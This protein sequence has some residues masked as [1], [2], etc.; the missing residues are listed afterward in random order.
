MATVVVRGT[1]VTPFLVVAVVELECFFVVLDR[2]LKPVQMELGNLKEDCVY[3]NAPDTSDRKNQQGFKPDGTP[4]PADVAKKTKGAII[5]DI[6]IHGSGGVTDVVHIF[7]LKFPCPSEE[8]KEGQW[9]VGQK[10]KYVRILK[11]PATLI[12]P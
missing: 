12:S 5:P 2:I 8:R 4:C 10:E 9:S 11:A 3:K 7:D 6:I 1:Q